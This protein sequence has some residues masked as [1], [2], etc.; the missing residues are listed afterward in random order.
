MSLQS[1]LR[2]RFLALDPAGM[3]RWLSALSP[4]LGI[5]ARRSQRRRV[6]TYVA[7]TGSVGKTTTT[8]LTARLL[9]LSGAV[10]TGAQVN[11]ELSV[12][13]SL[14]RLRQPA[15]YLVQE[16][17]AYPIGSIDR[18]LRYL[19]VDVALVTAVG[20]DHRSE[21]KTDQRVADEKQ[22]LV[23]AVGAA[24]LV[25]LNADYPLVRAMAKHTAARAVLFG[26]STDA[27]VRA[28]TITLDWQR[29]LGFDLVIGGA[30]RAVSTR[31]LGSAMLHNALGALS[32]IHGLGLDMDRA[33]A[34]LGTIEPL[35]D[36]MNSVTGADGNVY[37]IDT[38]KASHWST[39][40]LAD[41]LAEWGP[42]HKIFVL[43]NV[44]DTGNHAE[45]K[46]AQLLRAAAKSC[47]L[48]IGLGQAAGP[49]ERL[50]IGDTAQPE[51]TALRNVRAARSLSAARTLIAAAPRGLVILKGS[52]DLPLKRLLPDGTNLP[53][54]PPARQRLTDKT[55]T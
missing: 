42:G 18:M 14:A 33:I 43:G 26:R 15:D 52:R 40:M 4:P 47:D 41:D 17:S 28:E 36:R 49:A 20:L 2:T 55:A 7:V 12:F 8:N 22:K 1:W 30:R 53:K 23:A 5:F 38:A 32:V 44:S 51:K 35:L 46:Y 54:M 29:G 37:A 9:A 13:L 25:C 6:K 3:T 48:V 19:S 45:R 21:F 50:S 31:F 27:E 34:E 39:M 10:E 24:G 11:D 16:V